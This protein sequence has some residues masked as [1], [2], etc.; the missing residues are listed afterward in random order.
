M[1]MKL[2]NYYEYIVNNFILLTLNL[3]KYIYI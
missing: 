3:N 2:I 1:L